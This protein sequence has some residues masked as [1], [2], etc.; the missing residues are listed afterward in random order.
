MKR[1]GRRVAMSSTS[2]FTPPWIYT[3]TAP[4]ERN[5]SSVDLRCHSSTIASTHAEV[6][7]PSLSNTRSTAYQG[8]CIS[9][10][11]SGV[12]PGRT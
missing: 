10:Q 2:F 12:Q 1:V 9:P 11:H 8:M 5:I 4:T 3:N 7:F 6:P